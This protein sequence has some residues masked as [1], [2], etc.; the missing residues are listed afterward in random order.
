MQRTIINKVQCTL[1][2]YDVNTV[3]PGPKSGFYFSG[4]IDTLTMWCTDVN[5]PA[6]GLGQPNTM[7]GI[8]YHWPSS[9]GF[10]NLS[11]GGSFASL[12]HAQ[13]RFVKIGFKCGTD[14]IRGLFVTTDIEN[15]DMSFDV[16]DNCSGISVAG[17]F[18]HA[19]GFTAANVGLGTIDSAEPVFRIGS[20]STLNLLSAEFEGRRGYNDILAEGAGRFKIVGSVKYTRPS[21]VGYPKFNMTVPTYAIGSGSVSAGSNAFSGSITLTNSGTVN[22]L[23]M[24][25]GP[26]DT[27][28][29]SLA[30]TTTFTNTGNI[31]T[32]SRTTQNGTWSNGATAVTLSAPNAAII[33]GA[34][35]SGT[36][37][38]AGTTV[39]AV[40][41]TSLTLSLAATAAGSGVPLTFDNPVTATRQVFL[42]ARA[43]SLAGVAWDIVSYT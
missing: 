16:G 35:V 43:N 7:Y 17:A 25:N 1:S 12:Y 42:K 41:G 33:V 21:G 2:N 8:A 22:N 24:N 5:G 20:G 11:K 27:L 30:G 4:Q 26:D 14:Q 6:P 13:V 31:R 36:G 29:I 39:S 37:I 10:G 9:S 15:A 3:M 28:F 32:P 38:A 40:S 19:G 23:N 34:S 18:G